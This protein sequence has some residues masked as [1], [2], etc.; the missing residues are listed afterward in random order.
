MADTYVAGSYTFA[1]DD[2]GGVHTPRV[3]LQWGADNTVTDASAVAPLPTQLAALAAPGAGLDVVS[4]TDVDETEEQIKGSA[5]TVYGFY[6]YNSGTAKRYVRFYDNTAA[7]TTVGTTAAKMGPFTLEADQ[8]LMVPPGNAGTVF[9][10]GICIA[11]T[12]G[13]ASSNTGAPGADEV[14]ATIWYK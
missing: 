2:V 7:G 13:I 12:T 1:S 10:T 6:L 5:G 3:K 4:Y 11:A 9:A 14:Q 8:G